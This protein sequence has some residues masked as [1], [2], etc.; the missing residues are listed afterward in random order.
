[1]AGQLA[2]AGAGADDY[3]K[4]WQHQQQLAQALVCVAAVAARVTSALPM[5]L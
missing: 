4:L 1:M 3:C 2:D 5:Q